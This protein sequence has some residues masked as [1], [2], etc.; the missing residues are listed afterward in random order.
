MD[1]MITRH[2]IALLA[3]TFIPFG[4]V[5]PQTSVGSGN[6]SGSGGVDKQHQQQQGTAMRGELNLVDTD[7]F[8]D[9]NGNHSVTAFPPSSNAPNAP[10]KGGTFFDEDDEF[11]DFFKE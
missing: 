6:G 9:D 10:E 5:V 7:N 8:F 1:D 11:A 3:M 4:S 2:V